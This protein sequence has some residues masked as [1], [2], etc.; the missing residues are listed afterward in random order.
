MKHSYIYILFITYLLLT[1]FKLPEEKKYLNQKIPNVTLFNAKGNSFQLYSLFN[2]KPLIL[3][4]VYTKCASLCGIISNGTKDAITELGTLGKD[5]NVISF[6]FDSTDTPADLKNYEHRW[7][8]DGNYWKT[9]SANT[10]T[11]HELMNAIGYE[12]EVDTVGKQFNH[13]ALIIVLTPEGRISRYVYGVNP[14]KR[15]IRLAVMAA[16][17]EQTTPGLFSGIYLRCFGYDPLL[18]TYKVDWRF[19]I[20]TSAG[21]IIIFIVASIFIKSFILSKPDYDAKQ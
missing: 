7:S 3:V 6:S 21:F 16:K 19:I 5:F 18:R 11:I 15:D 13:P 10:I 2:N 8:M 20:S 4:P 1:G 14:S 17:A 9:V 12:Y